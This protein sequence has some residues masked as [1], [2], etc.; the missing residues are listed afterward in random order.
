[1]LPPREPAMDLPPRFSRVRAGRPGPT[2]PP[3]SVLTRPRYDA[4]R[5][6]PP[7]AQQPPGPTAFSYGE[8]AAKRPSPSPASSPARARGSGGRSSCPAERT[9]NCCRTA[10]PRA[11]F[12]ALEFS[13]MGAF[14]IP[15]I[16]LTRNSRRT[17][18]KFPGN[19]PVR[20][21]PSNRAVWRPPHGADRSA[22]P[23]VARPGGAFTSA[24]R[25]FRRVAISAPPIA[26][27]RAE[28]GSGTTASAQSDSYGRLIV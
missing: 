13:N 18:E 21:F 1:M 25:R 9:S 26:S 19:P 10:F 11:L 24:Y 3:M 17:I 22:L 23:A 5:P 6:M 28:A 8:A 20:D 12:M 14:A 16:I 2:S 4:S 7:S 27:R 15:I